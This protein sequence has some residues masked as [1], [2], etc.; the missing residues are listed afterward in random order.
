MILLKYAR[1]ANV[2]MEVLVDDELDLPDKLPGTAKHEE[3]KRQYS[4][5]GKSRR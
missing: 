5:R 2:P 3:I 4:S 1:A